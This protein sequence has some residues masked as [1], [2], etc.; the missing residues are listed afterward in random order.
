MN[1]SFSPDFAPITTSGYDS[2]IPILGGKKKTWHAKLIINS[3]NLRFVVRIR[4]LYLSDITEQQLES[5]LIGRY[6]YPS[7]QYEQVKAAKICRRRFNIR[8]L[9]TDRITPP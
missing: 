5:V 8:F 6:I 4:L 2:A 9:L 7:I 1:Q 3:E